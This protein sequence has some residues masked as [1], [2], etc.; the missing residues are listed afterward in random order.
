MKDKIHFSKTILKKSVKD[1][2][3]SPRW[4][5]IFIMTFFSFLIPLLWF[6]VSFLRSVTLASISAVFAASWDL[7]AGY[8]GQPNFGHALMFGLGAYGTA[9]LCKL[10]GVSPWITIPI[11]I[12]LTCALSVIIGFPLFRVRGPYFSLM[13][14]VFP[15]IATSIVLMFKDVT[16]GDRGLPCPTFFPTLSIMERRMAEY[17]LALVFLLFSGIILFK[18]AS[19][20]RGK[21][22]ISILD[23]ELASQACGINI[24][25][26]KL[27]ALIISNCF[28]CVAGSLYAS[29]VN[30]A[31][32]WTF[33]LTLSFYPVIWT[34]FGGVQT[35]YGAIF[36]ALTLEMLDRYILTVVFPVPQEWHMII[37]AIPIVIFIVKWRFGFVRFI[38]ETIKAYVI[39]S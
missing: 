34:V 18:I 11:N 39:K 10:W 5:L 24:V 32:L 25:K 8:C 4:M 28:A 16:R 35:I 21:T 30:L 13:S 12:L 3:T 31:S 14:M 22:F 29:I 36:G 1:W 15:Q 37:F 7:L 6:N 19:S 2:I 20:L 38:V 17:Y 9:L 23:D 27:E 33:S 26:Y